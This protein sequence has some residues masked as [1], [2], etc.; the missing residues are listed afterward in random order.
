MYKATWVV[1]HGTDFRKSGVIMYDIDEDLHSPMFGVIKEIWIVSGFVYFE[2]TPFQ[3]LCFSERFQAY[4]IRETVAAESGITSYESVVDF[5][6]FHTHQDSEGE[7][8][9][10]VKYDVGDL[11]EQHAKGENPLKF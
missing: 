11:I 6:V 5:N 2:Y 3:T 4:H 1:C 10:P 8:Y 7:N 9:V